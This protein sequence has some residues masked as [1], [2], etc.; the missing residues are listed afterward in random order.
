MS[1][2]TTLTRTRPGRVLTLSL[3]QLP[4]STMEL[5]PTEAVQAIM[6]SLS[7]IA[8]LKA[9]A[10]S[11]STFYHSFKASE[12][13][14]VYQI[15]L[16]QIG[17]EVL[18]EAYATYESSRIQR[19]SVET[20]R[21]FAGR[22]LSSRRPVPIRNWKLKDALVISRLH[23]DVECLAESY[24]ERA[25]EVRRKDGKEARSPSNVEIWRI[26]RALY[27]FEMY[28]NLFRSRQSIYGHYVTDQVDTFFFAF[29]P[30]ETEQ[31]A[32]I[33]EYLVGLVS[34]GKSSSPSYLPMK[35]I[36]SQRL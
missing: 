7:D 17:T 11:C 33:H 14:T 10:L 21:D 34:P 12:S 23:D 27:R 9:L 1:S 2:I 15:L 30:W 19:I 6:C 5:L 36:A 20:T 29:A 32:C 13:L 31:L 22:Y 24:V 28:C 25:M 26:E 16:N 8:S 4:K 35:L 18:P 3:P